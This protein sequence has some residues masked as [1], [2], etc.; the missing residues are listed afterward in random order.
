MGGRNSRRGRDGINRTTPLLPC[1]P[2]RLAIQRKSYLGLNPRINTIGL[3]L[4]STQ[5]LTSEKGTIVEKDNMLFVP[6]PF[7]PQKPQNEVLSSQN[8][9]GFGHG[10]PAML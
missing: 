7:M 5:N 9:S 4:L 2:F 1:H 10:K 8:F 3:M 6:R